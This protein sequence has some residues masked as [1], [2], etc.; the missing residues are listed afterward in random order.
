MI[1]IAGGEVEDRAPTAE[2][3]GKDPAAAAS[4][5]HAYSALGQAVTSALA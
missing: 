4:G 1:D 5:G 3:Q 2:E